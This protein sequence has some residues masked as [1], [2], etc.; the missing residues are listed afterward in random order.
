MVTSHVTHLATALLAA[1]PRGTAMTATVITL[2]VA[3]IAS[4]L[5]CTLQI[6][7]GFG[8]AEVVWLRLA[9]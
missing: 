2:L 6:H 4:T 9:R 1:A 7:A 5:A 8:H 3:T